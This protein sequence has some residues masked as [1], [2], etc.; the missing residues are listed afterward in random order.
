MEKKTILVVDDDK[1]IIQHISLILERV[2]YTVFEAPDV[3]TAIHLIFLKTPD[4]VILKLMLP[5]GNIS[6]I[7]QLLK[8]DKKYQKIPIVILNAKIN[9]DGKLIGEMMD[10][11]EYITKPFNTGDFINKIKNIIKTEMEM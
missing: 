1:N 2:G 3:N 5:Q 9:K 11:Q 6:E 4:L 8:N 10:V 7:C